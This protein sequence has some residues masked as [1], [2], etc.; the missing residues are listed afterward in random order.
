MLAIDLFR[1]ANGVP[2][3]ERT[4]SARIDELLGHPPG[5]G[6][7]LCTAAA[8]ARASHVLI[9]ARAWQRAARLTGR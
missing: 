4:V 1:R 7:G 8:K 9:L 2:V 6:C 5:C 3:T